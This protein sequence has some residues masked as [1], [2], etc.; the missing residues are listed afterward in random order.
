LKK[1]GVRIVKIENL[2]FGE[3]QEIEA[4][5]IRAFCKNI[6]VI[7]ILMY[8]SGADLNQRREKLHGEYG[9][10]EK[11]RD[12]IEH[13]KNLVLAKLRKEPTVIKVVDL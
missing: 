5:V 10:P 4:L 12:A 9:S 13:Y 7:L 8:F 3:A 2:T 11:C 6:C 1:K